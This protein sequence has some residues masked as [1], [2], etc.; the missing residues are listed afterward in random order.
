MLAAAAICMEIFKQQK[1][2]MLLMLSLFVIDILK[3]VTFF[4]SLEHYP[5]LSIPSHPIA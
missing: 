3:F 2:S 5:H 4:F 1:D